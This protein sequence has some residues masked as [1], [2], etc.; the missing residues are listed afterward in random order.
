MQHIVYRCAQQLIM[1]MLFGMAAVLAAVEPKP[2][3]SGEWKMNAEKSDFGPLPAP[4]SR[5]DKIDHQE[6]NL[7]IVRTQAS[8]Q[9][10]SVSELNCTTDG[11][12]CASEIRGVS[13]TLKVTVRW[14]GDALAFDSQGTFN[15]S[16]VQIKEKWMLS[17]D[18]NTIT[19]SRRLASQQGEAHQTIVLEKR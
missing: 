7:K 3:F 19:I 9:G 14:D 16:V 2:N 5:T 13:L 1:V 17:Q 6:P 15:E 10:E 11:R 8:L 4:K 12:E 18:G